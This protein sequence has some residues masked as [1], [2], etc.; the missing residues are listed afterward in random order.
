MFRVVSANV[1]NSSIMNTKIHALRWLHV[2]IIVAVCGVGFMSQFGI[3]HAAT[4]ITQVDA[5]GNTALHYAAKL[6][7]ALSVVYLL[8]RKADFQCSNNDMVHCN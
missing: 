1:G 5:N 2:L 4:N 8:H 7:A 3:A 6:G